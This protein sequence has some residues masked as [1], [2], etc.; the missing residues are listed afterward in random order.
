MNLEDKLHARL[1]R[2]RK[3]AK[4]YREAQHD[5]E[6]SEDEWLLNKELADLAE[7]FVDDLVEDIAMYHATMPT[8][9]GVTRLTRG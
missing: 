2:W 3:L 6:P 8:P 9:R 5:R 4:T 7:R 1:V